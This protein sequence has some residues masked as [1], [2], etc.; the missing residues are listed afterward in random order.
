MI[1][2]VLASRSSHLLV[3]AVVALSVLS[4]LLGDRAV[5]IHLSA[6]H[7]QNRLPFP[8]LCAVV[9]VVVAAAL[10]RPRFWEWDRLGTHRATAISV[11]YAL[12]GMLLPLTV[13][14][15]GSARLPAEV[16]WAWQVSNYL[17]FAGVAFCLGPLV[18][19]ALAGGATLVLYFGAGVVNHLLPRGRGFLPV[20]GYPGPATHWAFAVS[21]VLLALVVHGLTRG[22]TR[23]S[24][25]A[26]G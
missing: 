16:P 22:A 7:P 2:L 25:R 12:A 3:L 1:R 23:W 9:G 6:A 11:A 14:V 24:R 17:V 13:L 21:V 18:G 26:A 5:V 15:L 10:A 20:T 19:P 8:E 4:G